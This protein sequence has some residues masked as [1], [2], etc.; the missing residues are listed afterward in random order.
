M[1]E[2]IETVKILYRKAQDRAR[3]IAN[4]KRQDIVFKA[5]EQVLLST[6]NLQF[7]VGTRKFHPKFVGPFVIEKM[8]SEVAA[9]LKLPS[10]YGIHN[11]FHVCLLKH[12]KSG[13]SF[14]PLPPD[15]EIIDGEPYYKVEK[16]LSKRT[17]QVSYRKTKSGKKASVKTLTEYLIKWEG[18]DDTHN[19][20]EPEQNLTPDL[21]SEYNKH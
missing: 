1:H 3:V 10:T 11:V 8:I 15:P 13:G 7:K 21:I 4:S 18:Y 2:T 17:K 19:S 12:Y 6:K 14:K 9:K 5:G 16:I 20:W